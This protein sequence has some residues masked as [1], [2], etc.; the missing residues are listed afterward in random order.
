ME[1]EGVDA[2]FFMEFSWRWMGLC[3]V[4]VLYAR[5][6]SAYARLLGGYARSSIVYAQLEIS[7]AHLN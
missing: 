6:K 2:F 7:Y 5:L 1:K 4:A 3:S